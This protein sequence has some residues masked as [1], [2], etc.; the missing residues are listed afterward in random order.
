MAWNLVATRGLE[1]EEAEEE[2]GPS[3]RGGESGAATRPLAEDDDGGDEREPPPAAATAAE[4]HSRAASRLPETRP[5]LDSHTKRSKGPPGRGG[6][7]ATPP[8]P[9][10][11]SGAAGGSAGDGEDEEDASATAAAAPRK[12]VRSAGS[13]EH[14]ENSGSRLSPAEEEEKE[15]DEPEGPRWR[16]GGRGAENTKRR[17]AVATSA[18]LL[19]P[20]A[21]LA[22]ATP[23]MGPCLFPKE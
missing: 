21:T 5:A 17:S 3:E 23:P 4:A 18:T 12:F 6:T 14:V 10:T 9:S 22:S 1:G 15:E 16:G 11:L 2:N 8:A 7:R 20:S 19:A 13:G